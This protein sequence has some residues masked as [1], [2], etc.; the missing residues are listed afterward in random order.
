MDLSVLERFA[1]L[2]VRPGMLVALA[3]ALGG[4]HLPSQ[5]KIG[6]T[7]LLG[8]GLL[9][10]VAVPRGLPELTLAVVVAP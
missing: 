2:L 3:P 6:L 9:P 1:M 4:A 5:V 8:L 10:S 7:V